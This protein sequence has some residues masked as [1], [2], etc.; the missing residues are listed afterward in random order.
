MR[1]RLML[2]SMSAAAVTKCFGGI[3]QKL[4]T[5]E[6]IKFKIYHNVAF[7]SLYIST[8]FLKRLQFGE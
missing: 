7:D 8:G 4:L 1:F 3:S 2:S 5:I 6:A